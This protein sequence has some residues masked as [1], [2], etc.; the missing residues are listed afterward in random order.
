[1]MTNTISLGAASS[2]KFSVNL[3]T[4][5]ILCF[6]VIGVMFIGTIVMSYNNGT[7]VSEGLDVINTQSTP[8]VMFSSQIN[9]LVHSYEPAYIELMS[10]KTTE[11]LKQ[12]VEN[13]TF[14]SNQLN[15]SV[16]RFPLQ[17]GVNGPFRSTV[18]ELSRN[19]ESLNTLGTEI[20]N[21]QNLIV[22]YEEMGASVINQLKKLQSE[23]VPLAQNTLLEQEDEMVISTIN[24]VDASI[25]N[26]MWVIER[27][28][29]AAT[30]EE[31][32]EQKNL[33]VSWQNR[34]S[35]LLPSLIFAT[36]ESGFQNFV[37]E[38]S[39]LTLSLMDAI[40]GENGLLNIQQKKLEI[41]GQQT[42]SFEQF[43]VL[44]EEAGTNTNILLSSAF[45]ENNRLSSD[46]ND[47][48]DTQSQTIMIVGISIMIGIAVVSFWLTRYIRNAINQLME[49]L[50]ALSEGNLSLRSSSKS[51]DEFG[52]L[53]HYV[54][55]VATNLKGIVVDIESSAHQVD[56]S[57]KRVTDSSTMTR[58]IVQRQKAELEAIAAALVEMSSTA[59]EVASHTEA[60]HD[61]IMTAGNLSREGRKQVGSSRDSVEQMVAQT[62][63]TISAIDKLD[64]GVKSIEGII[65]T[66]TAI[67]EQT[68]LLALNA[69]IEAARAGD[70][71]RGFAVVADEVRSLAT[72]TQQSTLEIQNKIN[73][74][75]DDSKVAVNAIKQSEV[76]VSDSLKQ[77]TLADETITEVENTMAEIQDLSH[78]IS[79]AAEEQAVTLKELDRNINQ[80]TE[81]ADQTNN[82]A[83]QS[84]T[85]ALSQVSI[86]QDLEK[87]VGQFT[88]DR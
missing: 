27:L 86:V 25:T 62:E 67:A 46:I 3:T 51:D 48:V 49:G 14:I 60:T 30:L 82:Q 16:S 77:T 18:E 66:I 41:V 52:R 12:Q 32:N 15:A 17:E 71:G 61:K 31:L 37:R 9:Q 22:S 63:Q 56:T 24:A 44:L 81:L 72:R 38:L 78:L 6:L 40:E 20:T 55:T 84:E 42:Q 39:A 26:G 73:S 7:R 64:E 83:E 65:D 50:N 8:V 54:D 1:M 43:K 5:I 53:S 2:L 23:I 4:K 58:E 29:H 28:G 85:E 69:A 33:F 79:T 21:G 35:N 68:N 80:V 11:Q 57:V 76:L 10:S 36:Q 74:M 70:Q 19:I 34:H 88:F 59:G 87:K 47:A 13:I 75:I 45:E